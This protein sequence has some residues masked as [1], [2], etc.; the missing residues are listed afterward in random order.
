MAILGASAV[1]AKYKLA[2]TV[3]TKLVNSKPNAVGSER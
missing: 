1:M 3:K 2:A